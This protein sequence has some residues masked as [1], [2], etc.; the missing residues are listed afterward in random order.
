LIVQL[1]L[2]HLFSNHS[3]THKDLQLYINK[4]N[5]VS[6]LWI[7][8]VTLQVPWLMMTVRPQN[9]WKYSIWGGWLN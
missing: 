1:E 2:L 9:H 4:V 8:S 7:L 6:V 5:N 3:Q